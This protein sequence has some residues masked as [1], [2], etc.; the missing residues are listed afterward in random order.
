MISKSQEFKIKIKKIIII[1]K[2]QKTVFAYVSIYYASFG[3][4]IIDNF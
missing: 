3:T 1:I 2:S 4:K